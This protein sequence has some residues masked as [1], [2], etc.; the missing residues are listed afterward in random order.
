[1]KLTPKSDFFGQWGF[2]DENGEWAIQPLFDSVC[3]FRGKYAKVVKM[4]RNA[5][6]IRMV[7]ALTKYL[8]STKMST[9]I[10]RHVVRPKKFLK[11]AFLKFRVS[12]IK[13]YII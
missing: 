9:G 3:S 8:F 1:M 7:T 2:V 6:L 11:I 10:G 12:Y 5:M 4:A 13:D